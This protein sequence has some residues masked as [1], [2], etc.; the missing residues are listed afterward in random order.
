M[1]RLL[2]YPKHEQMFAVQGWNSFASVVAHFLPESARRGKVTV[3]RVS[4]S[5]SGG[6]VDA[7]FKLYD[8]G[9]SPWSFWLRVSKAR[10]EFENYESF[11]RLGVPAAEPIACGEERD[12][13]GR[14]QRAFIITRT[15]PDTC[16]LIDF[17]AGKP[18]RDER[19]TI[20]R[21]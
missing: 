19:S 3:K 6:E 20:I 12:G 15:V 16:T 5:T 14:V 13:L 1:E 7:F 10:R 21:D 9:A 17:F 18:S 11:S 2:V 4:I 8:H